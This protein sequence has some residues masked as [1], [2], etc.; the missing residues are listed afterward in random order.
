MQSTG[1]SF[2]RR[3]DQQ[4][5]HEISPQEHEDRLNTISEEHVHEEAAANS[6]R[7]L[8]KAKLQSLRGLL[9]SIQAD[10]WMYKDDSNKVTESRWE[11]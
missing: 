4:Q 5:N 8:L 10:N 6:H 3:L 11:R 9:Q 2:L 7:E 1:N